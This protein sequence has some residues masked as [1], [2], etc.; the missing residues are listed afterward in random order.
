MRER[1]GIATAETGLNEAVP[2]LVDM[3]LDSDRA[4]VGAANFALSKIAGLPYKGLPK[5]LTGL[6]KQW[7]E[8]WAENKGRFPSGGRFDFS[9]GGEADGSGWNAV[10]DKK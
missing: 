8:W 5:E 7:S 6:R 4:A 1:A 2:I 10:V 9:Y 3:L